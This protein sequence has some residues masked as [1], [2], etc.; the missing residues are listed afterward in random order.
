M[1]VALRRAGV[2]L[3]AICL[4]ILSLL[5]TTVFTYG[6][7]RFRAP[8]EASVMLLAA[9]GVDYLVRRRLEA[10]AEPEADCVLA[11]FAR[12]EPESASSV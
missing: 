8:S 10:G 3:L 2:P 11:A 1:R 7:G 9:I 6:L 5:L 4:P 12:R